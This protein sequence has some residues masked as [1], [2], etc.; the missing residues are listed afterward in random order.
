MDSF[1]IAKINLGGHGFNLA[2]PNSNLIHQLMVLGYSPRI[3]ILYAKINLQ[4][5]QSSCLSSTGV[6]LRSTPLDLFWAQLE[7]V[8]SITLKEANNVRCAMEALQCGCLPTTTKTSYRDTL[9]LA[10]S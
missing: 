1:A 6:C 8:A 9:L 7:S 4:W 5:T 2:K 3:E 10:F